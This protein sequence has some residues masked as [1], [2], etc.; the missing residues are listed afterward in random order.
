[1]S[2][3]LKFFFFSFLLVLFYS[4][5]LVSPVTATNEFFTKYHITYKIH[6]SGT[7]TVRQEISLTNKLSRLY[8][9]QYTLNTGTLDIQNVRAE[10]GLGPIPVSLSRQEGSTTINLSFNEKVVGKG[11]TL[12]FKLEYETNDFVKQKGQI[13]EVIIPK[14]ANIQ[15]IDEYQMVLEVPQNFNQPAYISPKPINQQGSLYIFDKTAAA[16]GIT[17]A[18]GQCQI[19]DFSIDYHLENPT[20][21]FKNLSVVFP[22]DT[23]YQ[24]V[25]YQDV[26]PKP[27]EIT[28]DQ[29]GNWL[30]VYQLKPKEK[31]KVKVKGTVQI[32]MKPIEEQKQIIYNQEKY[33]QPQPYWESDDPKIQNLARQLVSPKKIYEFVVKTLNYDYRRLDQAERLGAKKALE[34]PDKALCMEFTDLFIALAR[35]A[36]IPAREI[37]GFAYTQNPRLKPLSLKRDVLHAWPEY[38]D[39]RRKIWI[40][41]DPTWEETTGGVDFFNKLDLNHFVLVIHGQ[42]SI[43]PQP[44]GSEPEKNIEVSFAQ[45]LPKI[46]ENVKVNFNLPKKSISGL[47]LNGTIQIINDGNVALH[48]LNININSL[49]YKINLLPP[50]TSQSFPVNLEKISWWQHQQKKI[51][52]DVNQYHFEHRVD[53]R[54]FYFQFIDFLTSKF[55]SVK[56]LLTR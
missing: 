1:M 26:R 25:I 6:P 22:P 41:I 14:I 47:P 12:K 44:P 43:L 45:D 39:K 20:L 11:K 55:L 36:G 8:A 9:T 23:T 53:F 21:N 19:F 27:K 56:K 33:L 29:D 46:K 40:P 37:N 52:V 24:K 35:A 31:I 7:T 13:W 2:K 3:K 51:L 48:H 17:A 5:A 30:A 49:K 28:L 38:W 15:T 18:F 16:K 10:D 34:N 4:F 32:L 50:F 54:P 42:N